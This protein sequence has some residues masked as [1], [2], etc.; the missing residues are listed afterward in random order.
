M[1]G[2]GSDGVEIRC[3]KCGYKWTYTGDLWTTTCPRCNKKTKTQLHPENQSEE[4]E[5]SA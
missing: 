2:K 3:D 4:S 1:T 5:A